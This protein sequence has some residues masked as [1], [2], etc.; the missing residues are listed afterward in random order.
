LTELFQKNQGG[1]FFW[2]TLYISQFLTQEHSTFS[3]NN[4][5]SAVA[6]TGDRF[7][8]T[9]MGRKW[10]GAAVGGWVPI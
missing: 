10:R 3:F 1:P 4:K 9:G 7:A 8:T 2:P 5:S 6:E